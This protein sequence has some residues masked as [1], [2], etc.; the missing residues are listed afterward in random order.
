MTCIK[1]SAMTMYCPETAGSG[2]GNSSLTLMY[3]LIGGSIGLLLGT[4]FL[5][6][7]GHMGSRPSAGAYRYERAVGAGVVLGL[8]VLFAVKGWQTL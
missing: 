2:G 1:T 4:W 7:Q 6:R 5:Y 3:M 8:V